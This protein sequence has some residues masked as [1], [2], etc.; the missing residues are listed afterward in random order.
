MSEALATFVNIILPLSL[1]KLYTYR[2]PRELENEIQVGMRVAV[3]FGNKRIYAGIIH[4][5]HDKPPKDY[6]AKYILDVLDNEPCVSSLTL[7]FWKWMAAYYMCSLGEVMNAALPSALKPE[8]QT[9]I[10]LNP[11]C[12]IS[13][14]EL[15]DRE[16]LIVEA[17]T[18][19]TTLQID[20]IVEIIQLKQVFPL[21]KSLHLKGAILLQEKLEETY[22]P[23]LITCIKLAEKYDNE[24]E[25]RLLFEQLEKKESQ[26]NVL[27][28]YMQLKHERPNIE[29]KFLLNTSH[30][31]ESSLNT[32]IK[33]NIFET[34]PI[35]VD[36]LS[37][38][39]QTAKESF[40]LNEAQVIALNETKKHFEQKQVVLMHGITSS[41]KTHIY[42]KLIEEQIKIG[43]Q[44]LFLLPE[45]ALTSQV[46]A[47]V[48]KY[49]GDAAIAY[50]SKFNS[51]ERL[52][53]WQKVHDG[54]AQ[55]IIGAR[56]SIF[57]P[58][59]N[60]GLIIVDE[61]HE[62]S[63]KQPD[64]SPRY[65]AR[66]C[67]I[68]LS[69]LYHCKTL[70]GSATP[71]FE[72]YYNA[73]HD[74]YGLV[75]LSQRFGEIALPTIIT[76]NIAEERRVK[77]IKGNFTEVLYNAIDEALNKNEQVILFQNR[78]GYS[79]IYEC[80]KC[81]HIVKCK[82]CDIS[83][84][85]HKYNDT[86][87]CHYCG[88][89]IPLMKTCVACGSHELALKGLG[90]EKIEDELQILFPSARISRLDLDTT[91]SKKGHTEIIKSFE[92]H[93]ADILV[94]TQMLS[95]G[96]DFGAVS[97]VGVINADQLLFFPDF[98]AHERAYQ[99]LTQVSGRAGRRSKQG[100]VIIQTS[101]PQHHVLQEV[102]NYRF[103]TLYANEIEERRKY[104]YPPFSR[105][106]LIKIKHKDY[107]I[108][109]DAGYE[110]FQLLHKRLGQYL[111]GPETPYV[112]RIKNFYIKEILLKLTKDPH[113]LNLH[114][115]YMKECI[116]KVLESKS[117]KGCIIQLDVD[118]L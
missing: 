108:A 116:Q 83:L 117:Y 98:R 49:F 84:T 57:L 70:L 92:A 17:L 35:Q 36:R 53:L 42:V 56:S 114:K 110:L 12:D 100:N 3:Q 29:K 71:S 99:L 65:N 61:E 13:S 44:V 87:K 50:H 101:V 73:M 72:S 107:R 82:N 25:L 77:T 59:H 32:L 16:Y 34:Y 5:I 102:I 60:L 46:I 8:S 67:A 37:D 118:P 23:K 2:I 104:N 33:K 88:Y 62:Q 38:S 76:A 54:S 40:D 7:D 27:L 74:K 31:S 10:L 95:K 113:T 45:I 105:I 115:T 89:T 21:L 85:Y 78:R 93:D 94:G 41:G 24:N 43:K 52:E 66:D 58:F 109:A 86:L 28:A 30:A 51:N 90:T 106:I 79:P 96:L 103:G 97:I 19:E 111:V 80:L 39:G 11:E 69:K 63:Y 68:I 91:R 64:P 15:S 112:S 47:R 55:I 9:N 26:L 14:L 22:K 20:D 1:P 75:K 81:Q 48:K 4:D 6:E 18:R